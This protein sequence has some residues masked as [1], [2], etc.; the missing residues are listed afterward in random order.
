MN[1]IKQHK[2]E[3]ILI[4]AVVLVFVAMA[5]GLRHQSREGAKCEAR[6]GIYIEA[7]NGEYCVK[8]F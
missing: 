5:F 7:R 8:A 2:L 4:I 1:W 6:G 3:I